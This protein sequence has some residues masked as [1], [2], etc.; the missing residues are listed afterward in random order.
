LLP[1]VNRGFTPLHLGFG[2]PA[3]LAVKV[4]KILRLG[5]HAALSVLPQGHQDGE[6]NVRNKDRPLFVEALPFYL[7]DCSLSDKR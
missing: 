7:D 4:A 3:G 5:F 2:K 1:L 6:V